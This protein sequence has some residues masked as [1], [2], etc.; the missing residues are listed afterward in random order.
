MG[1]S[2]RNGLAGAE[3]WT[4]VVGYEGIYAVSSAGQVLSVRNGRI[5]AGVPDSDGYPTVKL[6][7]AGK[8]TRFKVHRLVCAAFH[9][10][11][12]PGYEVAHLDGSK[13]NACA[14]NLQWCTPSENHAHKRVHGTNRSGENSTRAMM[15]EGLV[16]DILSLTNQGYSQR[17]IAEQVGVEKTTVHRVQRGKTRAARKVMESAR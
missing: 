7:R 1:A 11:P 17:Q 15:P 16:R 8:G 2:S 4:P 13:T 5:M 12:P 10:P 6:Y 9:G 3:A 14:D